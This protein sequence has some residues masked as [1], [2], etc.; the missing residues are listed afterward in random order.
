MGGFPLYVRYLWGCSLLAQLIVMTLLVRKGNFRKL[1]FFTFYTALN[2]C[3][4]G[5]LVFVYQT[6]GNRSAITLT[7]ASVSETVTLLAQALATTEV[8]GIVLKPY[9]GIWG[10]GWRAL[11]ATSTTVVILVAWATRTNWP[12]AKWFERNQ[13]YHLT[14][15][16]DLLAFFILVRYY[17]IP[18]PTAYKII[19]IGFCF[20]S[21][22][23]LLI[24]TFFKAV[25]YHSYPGHQSMWQF[26]TMFSF[27]VVLFLWVV[28]LWKPLPDENRQIASPSDL[29]YQRL[30]PEINE[31]LRALNE[32]LL[33]L[34]ILE[35]RPN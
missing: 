23:E 26:S 24:C 3:Q 7:L 29:A 27:V 6:Y 28:A 21:C 17:S 19:L 32:K 2:I 18:V 12:L 4:A 11:A 15:A 8:L 1:P 9:Q 30:S 14:F 10:L 31:Q 16:T 33:R 25:F 35:A 5:F 34:W 20:Y 13:G 22:T